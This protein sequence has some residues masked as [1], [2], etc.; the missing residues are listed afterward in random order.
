MENEQS[1]QESASS[2][3]TETPSL[4]QVYKQF[5][6]EAEAQS[7]RPQRPEAH[8]QVQQQP[9]QEAVAVPDPVLDP[10][11]YKAWAGNQ[12]EFVQKAIKNLE[13]E[14]TGMRV[15]RLRA[16]EE[17]DIKSAVQR[18]RSVTG[19]DVDEDVAEVALGSKARRDPKF[20]AVYQNR[21][22]N[23]AA[24]HAAVNAYAN[25]FKSKYQFKVDSQIAENQRAAKL[26]IGSQTRPSKEEP[27][28]DE[29]H[30]ANKNGSE[31]DRAWR[32]YIDRGY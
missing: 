10:N 14:L 28:G 6:V 18:F 15:E 17:A 2:E 4:E 23:P 22:K 24:W 3:Q 26:S 5:N 1:N 13:G 31:F 7:F 9:K 27:S 16:K 11:G 32:N 25:E 21:G 29:K 12:H 8:E 30:F 19:D 20:L